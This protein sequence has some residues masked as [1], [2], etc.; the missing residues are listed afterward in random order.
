MK[1]KTFFNIIAFLPLVYALIVGDLSL[2][3]PF[4]PA[5]FATMSIWII[6]FLYS[7]YLDKKI[8]DLV[9]DKKTSV[10]L[11]NVTWVRKPLWF[12]TIFILIPTLILCAT[13]EEILFRLPLLILFKDFGQ[14]FW[15]T[16]IGI[17]V[18]F[19]LMH[20]QNAD[21]LF[22]K[23]TKELNDTER[24]VFR[25]SNVIITAT[26]GLGL[27]YFFMLTKSLPMTI[28]AHVLWNIFV[29]IVFYFFVSGIFLLKDAISQ[30]RSN[31]KHRS[32]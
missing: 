22:R 26:F 17:S 1:T 11:V 32:Y 29:P 7:I 9:F 2:A 16:A 30:Y 31:R 23:T 8:S 18:I 28:A 13:G 21:T 27:S 12:K 25:S 5:I 10:W 19:G 20:W 4:L 6:L 15:V 14:G 3:E 24:L